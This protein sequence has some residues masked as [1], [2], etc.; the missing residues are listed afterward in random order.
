[1]LC[2]VVGLSFVMSSFHVWVANV[3]VAVY[4]DEWLLGSVNIGNIIVVSVAVKLFLVVVPISI[5]GLGDLVYFLVE[6]K[7]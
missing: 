6:S 7:D 3:M 1:M 4:G 5:G 2:G